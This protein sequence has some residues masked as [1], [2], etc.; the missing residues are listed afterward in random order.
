MNSI[1]IWE[2]TDRLRRPTP[3]VVELEQAF[4]REN[5]A[6]HAAAASRCDGEHAEGR[7]SALAEL[8]PQLLRVAV[9]SKQ[10]AE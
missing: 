8:P 2:T 6:C 9:R 5:A 10:R 7:H 3:L 1:P 4:G